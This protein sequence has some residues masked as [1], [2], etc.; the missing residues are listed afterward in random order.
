M[1]PKQNPI[2]VKRVPISSLHLDPANARLH[3]EKNLESIHGSLKRF[4]QVEPLVVQ[5]GT[6]RVIGGNGRLSVMKQIGWTECDVVEVDLDDMNATAL[7]IA[8]NRS[9]SLGEW[10]D[11]TLSKILSELEAGNALDGI[12]YSQQDMA[13]LA[14]KIEGELPPEDFDDQG[15]E[16]PPVE[17]ISMTGD[18]WVLDRHRL[19]CGDS[20]KAEDI[21]RLLDG[22]K[23][24]LLATDPPYGVEYT[25]ARGHTYAPNPSGKDW[26][27]VFQKFDIK[28]MDEFLDSVFKAVIP[29]VVDN[30]AIYV[31]HA[32]R[33]HPALAETFEKHDLLL[34]QVIIWVK[35]TASFGRSYYRWRHEP[36]A[37]GWKLGY[38]PHGGWGELETVWEVDWEGKSRVV[39]NEHPTQKPLRLFEIP[40]E[41]HTQAGAIV[42]EPFSGSGSQLLAAEKLHRRCRAM[43]ISPAFVDVG[44][45]RWEKATGKSAILH[46]TTMT[47]TEVS[48]ERKGPRT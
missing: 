45:R 4:D 12:G 44:V 38:K 48:M 42:L 32:D 16:E 21:A 18:L 31:W 6:G 34:H 20:T 36:C 3:G 47:F 39:G 23:A 35:P 24:M 15:P 37:F 19:L 14:A 22:E 17:P 26:S 27:H 11:A 28:K 25:G 30:A 40:M 7:G 5:K 10:D 29:H 1:K 41:Q 43:E 46:G 9:S 33:R 2:E 13:D 8:L